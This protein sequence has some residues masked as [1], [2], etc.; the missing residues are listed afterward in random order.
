MI[1]MHCLVSTEKDVCG[2]MIFLIEHKINL[3]LCEI[4]VS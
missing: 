2:N 3:K 4:I 1:S